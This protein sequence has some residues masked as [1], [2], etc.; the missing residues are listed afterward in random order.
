M[1]PMITCSPWKPVAIKKVLPKDESAMQKDASIYSNP[2]N[3]EKIE[4]NK[5]VVNKDS[6]A[7][8]KFFLVSHDGTK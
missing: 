7:L 6:F 2:W 5:M 1:E 3:T 8:L 4:P